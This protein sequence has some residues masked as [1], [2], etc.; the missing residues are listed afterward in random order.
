MSPAP[1][2]PHRCPTARAYRVVVAL[3]ACAIPTLIAAD[4]APLARGRALAAIDA[5]RLRSHVL[6]L[7]SNALEGRQAGL[8]GERL[9]GD[10][11][12][13]QLA[14]V[15]GLAPAGESG[16]WFQDVPLEEGWAAPPEG[17]A[18]RA[19]EPSGA[20]EVLEVERDFVPL[21]QSANA[22]VAG[23]GAFV[24]YAIEAPEEG[25]DDFAG[26]ELAGR[27][28]FALR[29][30]PRVA[31]GA[32]FG[33]PDRLTPHAYFRTKALA[34]Q[35]R[36][37]AAL[38]LLTRP[39]AVVP[40]E[41]DLLIEPRGERDP[42][43]AIPVV[44]LRLA[45]ARRMLA[46]AGLDLDQ[47]AR[48]LDRPG[49]RGTTG[50]PAWV[51][52]SCS[53]GLTCEVAGEL[54]PALVR[55]RNVLARLAG[56]SDQEL[57]VVGAHYDHIGGGRYGGLGGEAARERI[58]NGADDN[59]SGTA[60]L[61]EIARALATCGAR[62]HRTVVFVAF[63]AEELGLLGSRH[64]V[65]QPIAPIERHVAMVNLDM[66]AR[67]S[68]GRFIV[69]GTG[70][71]PSWGP[72][73][74]R[75]QPELGGSPA[76]VAGGVAPSDSTSFHRVGIPTLFFFTGL[77]EDYH[78][79]TDDVDRLDPDQHVLVA[80][81]AL[82][83]TWALAWTDAPRPTYLDGR[84]AQR[85]ARPFLGVAQDAARGAAGGFAV[86]R[87]VAGASAERA[88]IRAGDLIVRVGTHAVDG[89]DALTRAIEAYKVGDAVEVC[90]ER[91]GARTTVMVVLM[92]RP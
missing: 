63:G 45:V 49:P 41:D 37:G 57:V 6:V 86:A 70:T 40:G 25:Y 74:D 87:V 21:V 62:P 35:K 16:G 1:H 10:Y 51:R 11:V 59:A 28:A 88:G 84:S 2:V 14:G 12:A 67:G 5:A 7:A 58:H 32:A 72:L 36:G 92:D 47:A 8:R 56:D 44:H 9:A 38:V 34:V 42:D 53:L 22:R 19:R 39:D 30:E 77:H 64:Y 69:S 82:A 43:I 20:W 27:V 24:G 81:W 46:R 13:V 52:S 78:R 73:L 60:A 50:R 31:G 85:P 61:V 66:V 75:L 54:T 55:S 4:D 90:V 33:G 65:D 18:F 76:R 80:R 26:I 71:S 83:A 48:A 15:G 29:G 89:I 68:G 17:N 79:P 23:D 91:D 3:L